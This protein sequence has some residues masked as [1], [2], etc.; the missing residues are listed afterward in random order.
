M[1]TFCF[2]LNS[3]AMREYVEPIYG[4][5]ID[6]PRRYHDEWF[7]SERFAVSIIED[8]DGTAIGAL[9]VRDEDD[10]SYA[11]RIAVLPEAQ[12]RGVGTAV[13]EDLIGRGRTTRLDVFTNNVRAT[14]L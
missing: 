12:G 3:V 13:M 11:S 14:V 2:G 4:W 7:Q 1:T 10:H 9:D 8:D 5:D 6:V